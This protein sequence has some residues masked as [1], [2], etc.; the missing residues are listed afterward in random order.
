MSGILQSVIGS[1]NAPPPP[2]WVVDDVF[3][4]D[5]YTGTATSTAHQIVNGIDL[6]EHG[7]LVWI[8]GLDS[9][10]AFDIMKSHVLEDKEFVLSSNSTGSGTGGSDIDTFN[11][12]G[13][14]FNASTG[15]YTDYSG[16]DYVSWTFRK[17]P[18]FFDIVT[19]TGD[20]TNR[21]IAHNLGSVPGCI[22]IK[23]TDDTSHWAV[24]HRSL[25]NT[26]YLRLNDMQE[27][28]TGSHWNNT[29]PT[30]SVFTVGNDTESNYTGYDYVA[31]IFAHDDEVFGTNRN[32]DIIQCGGFT[33]N[34]TV[35]LGW[36]PQYI[37]VKQT[38]NGYGG[39]DSNW[40]IADTERGL[41]AST[42]HDILYANSNADTVSNYNRINIT[43][44]GFTSSNYGTSNTFIYIA[45]RE[46]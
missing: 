43:S 34:T 32:K 40:R 30:D 14:T 20:S 18:G 31:Y 29:T 21:N 23:R 45:I 37:L 15:L 10:Q 33:G 39:A 17:A 22:M 44:S 42:A 12:N 13:W 24:Y 8:K 9:S 11:S 38:D 1:L 41:H 46:E 36:R 4:T 16:S 35:S 2:I 28:E 3:S 7:G 26:E 6:D 19:W 25:G 5:L 27:A